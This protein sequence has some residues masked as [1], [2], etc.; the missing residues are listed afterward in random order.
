[1]KIIWL[2]PMAWLFNL[3]NLSAQGDATNSF[4]ALAKVLRPIVLTVGGSPYNSVWF[5]NV[6]AGNVVY[7]DPRGTSS[8]HVS[9]TANV[10]KITVTATNNEPIRLEYPDSLTLMN[11]THRIIYQPRISAIYGDAAVNPAN[12]SNSVAVASNLAGTNSVTGPNGTGRA[13]GMITTGFSGLDLDKTTL[14]I[15]GMLYGP[16]SLG[17]PIPINQEKGFYTNTFVINILYQ[18]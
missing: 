7:L 8:E 11:G 17:S 4:P 13:P 3:S 9:H 6:P 16:A 14:F 10:A 15:G 1:M 2:L 5:G 12:Q 18:N